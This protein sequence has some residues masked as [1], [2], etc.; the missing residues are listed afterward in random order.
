MN[1]FYA[2]LISLQIG[3]RIVVPKSNLDLVQHHAIFIGYENGH[4]WFI[5]NKDG[6]GVRVV[7]ADVFFTGVQKITR[8][9][10]FQPKNGYGRIELVNYALSKKGMR[11]HL[12]NYNCEHFANEVQHRVVK[13]RQADTGVG[14]A[15][16]GLAALLIGGLASAGSKK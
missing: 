2:T 5:E 6:I 10:P 3:D 13:S 16:F 15:L 7:N 4:F 1:R 8:I 9:V 12:T 14:L 11:Y